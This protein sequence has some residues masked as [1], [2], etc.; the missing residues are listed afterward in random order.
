M[1]MRVFLAAAVILLSST[2]F[3]EHAF[4]LEPEAA[5]APTQAPAA[6][7]PPVAL[8]APAPTPM[9]APAPQPAPQVQAMLPSEVDVYLVPAATREVCTVSN[10]GFGEIRS[11]CRSEA[12]PP[13]HGNPA[14]RGICTTRY[15]LRTC[16]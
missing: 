14:L 16:Y 8:P 11:D 1:G 6:A 13:R 9:V 4:T 12:L 3:A 15:G 7:E 2:A 5:P 10:W